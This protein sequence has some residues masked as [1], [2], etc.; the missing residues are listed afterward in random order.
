MSWSNFDQSLS[1]AL[2]LSEGGLAKEFGEIKN[3][4]RPSEIAAVILPQIMY[5][6]MALLKIL[7]IGVLG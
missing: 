6:K 3:W 4:G 5:F 1:K 7:S 2:D